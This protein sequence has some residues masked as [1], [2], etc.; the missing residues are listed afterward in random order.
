MPF[1]CEAVVAFD[2]PRYQLLEVLYPPNMAMP[3]SLIE[4]SLRAHGAEIERY[5]ARLDAFSLTM[6]YVVR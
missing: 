4:E 2:A 6:P 1:A 3:L 5:P